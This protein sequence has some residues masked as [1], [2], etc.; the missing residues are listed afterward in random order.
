MDARK[1]HLADARRSKAE[2]D[3]MTTRTYRYFVCINGHKGVEKTSENDQP[4][5]S[6]W[7]S[8]STEGLRE[9]GTD[10]LGYA[11]YACAACGQMMKAV[12]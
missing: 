3:R 12:R 9:S 1:T 2:E 4:Y 6:N 8:V 5:S 11:T 10:D 7:E